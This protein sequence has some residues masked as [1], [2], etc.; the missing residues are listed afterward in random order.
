M[1]VVLTGLVFFG[2]YQVS[3]VFT[4]REI[5]FHAAARGARAKTVGFNRWM[6]EKVIRVAAISTA[7]EM[8]EPDFVN[9]D[10]Y[11]RGLTETLRPGDLFTTVIGASPSSL[12]YSLERGRIPE[13]LAS[14]ESSTA[15]HVLN[16]E[17]WDSLGHETAVSPSGQ[18]GSLR[19]ETRQ[20]YQLTVPM[21]RAFYADDN[22]IL[23][24]EASLE[25]HYQLY[26]DDSNW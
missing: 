17:G 25:S 24:G 11:I 1:A 20:E 12:Q 2:L 7:G 19:V 3:R 6:V 16:Y 18:G 10:D 26:L 15:R 5:L 13:Y 9:E 4:A 8:T 14:T 22:I 23:N 21:H